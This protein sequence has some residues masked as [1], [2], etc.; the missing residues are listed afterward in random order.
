MTGRPSVVLRIVQ[1]SLLMLGVGGVP[2]CTADRPAR[3]AQRAT[4]GAA[5]TPAV[6][7][8]MPRY[9]QAANAANAEEDGTLIAAGARPTIVEQG[10]GV[11]AMVIRDEGGDRWAKGR[12]R[13][14]VHCAGAGT[15]Y[16]YFRLGGTSDIRELL[17]CGPSATTSTVDLAIKALSSGSAV[18]IIPAGNAQAAVSYQIQRI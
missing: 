11:V 9:V 14:V 17:P 18:L 12:Y 7:P 13:L 8:E 4:P 10:S 2:A 1:A 3:T 6:T 15:L 16:A 5:A